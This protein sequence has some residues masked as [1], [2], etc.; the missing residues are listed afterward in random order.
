MATIKKVSKAKN[1]SAGPSKKTVKAGLVDPKGQYTK[2][3]ERTL[4]SMKKGGKIKKAQNGVRAKADNTRVSKL[5]V[6]AI[7]KKSSPKYTEVGT[8]FPAS[9]MNKRVAG[10]KAQQLHGRNYQINDLMDKKDSSDYTKGYNEA[11]NNYLQNKPVKKN[12]SKYN[13][14]TFDE[15]TTSFKSRG[16]REGQ[17]ELGFQKRKGG[18]ITKAKTGAK[19]KK[20]WIQGAVNPKH[21]G[22]CTPMTKAT[23]TPKRK[24]LAMTFKKMAKKK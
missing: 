13:D 18:K 22:Y 4:G 14:Q 2:V 7:V 8:D 10:W 16:Y 6:S 19:V 5:P 12:I 9:Q 11:R 15:D 20:N 21:K 1:L 23:C 17:K 3:Q 24:A